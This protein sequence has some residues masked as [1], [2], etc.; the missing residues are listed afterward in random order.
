MTKRPYLTLT[1]L[2]L[3]LIAVAVQF[4]PGLIQKADINPPATAYS[5]TQGDTTKIEVPCSDEHPEWR[6]AQ[7]IDGVDIAAA[8]SCEPDNPYDVAA[9]VSRDQ[10]YF[11]GDIDAIQFGARCVGDGR[12]RRPRR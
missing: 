3:V 12:R 6:Q 8:P 7:V 5:R 9:S 10:Q 1:I 2:I 11:D 4:A